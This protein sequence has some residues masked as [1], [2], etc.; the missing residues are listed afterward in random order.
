MSCVTQLEGQNHYLSY[1]DTWPNVA[2][3]SGGS[4]TFTVER[5]IGTNT[6]IFG[7]NNSDQA[8]RIGCQVLQEN[9]VDL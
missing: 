7:L 5:A 3:L 4:M 8:C 9:V 1:K 6:K 2:I